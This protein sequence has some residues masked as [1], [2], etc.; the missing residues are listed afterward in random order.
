MVATDVKQGSESK[1]SGGT[2]TYLFVIYYLSV[3]RWIVPLEEMASR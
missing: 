1:S 3:N 2:A